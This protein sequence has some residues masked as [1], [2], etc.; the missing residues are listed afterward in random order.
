MRCITFFSLTLLIFFSVGVFASELTGSVVHNYI[1]SNLD[2][3]GKNSNPAIGLKRKFPK[4]NGNLQMESIFGSWKTVKVSCT[5]NDWS[6]VVRTNINTDQPVSNK[7]KSAKNDNQEF[8]VVLKTS[9]NKGD[10]IDGRH[11]EY[12]PKKIT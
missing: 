5:S 4:C 11:L 1:V 2:K 7:L 3:K 9:L 6:I 12:S 8:V 10:L